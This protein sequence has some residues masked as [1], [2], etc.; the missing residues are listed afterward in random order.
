ML[1]WRQTFFVSAL[2]NWYAAKTRNGN[3]PRKAVVGILF[4]SNAMP[5]GCATKEGRRA[6]HCLG[7]RGCRKGAGTEGISP[8]GKTGKEV[9]LKAR[10]YGPPGSE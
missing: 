7:R 5:G 3:Y 8:L 6:Y 1:W 4:D 9:V 10:K 2:E